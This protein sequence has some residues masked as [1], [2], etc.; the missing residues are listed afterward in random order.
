[1]TGEKEIDDYLRDP[2][3]KVDNMVHFQAVKY[4]L[5]E[6]DLY[7]RTIDGVFL[8]C[9]EKEKSKTLMGKIHEGVCGAHQ[10]TFMS[11]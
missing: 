5:L 2:S 4:V 6:G 3:K 11:A 10:L 7:Y 9:L 1:M 8:K